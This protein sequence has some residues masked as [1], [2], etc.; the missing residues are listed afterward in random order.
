MGNCNP[1]CD[2]TQF[3]VHQPGD[4]DADGI[5]VSPVQRFAD[6][7]V[8]AGSRSTLYR[9]FDDGFFP[10]DNGIRMMNHTRLDGDE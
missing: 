7:S 2:D 8:V 9:N 6:E 3:A 5:S 1:A 4:A 10:A